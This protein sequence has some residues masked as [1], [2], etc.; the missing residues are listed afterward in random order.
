M[1]ASPEEK[2]ATIR[3]LKS[4]E[5]HV[6]GI[7]RMIEEDAYCMEVILQIRA[8]QAALEKV[9]KLSLKDHL[10]HCVVSAVRGD[11]PDQREKVL[12]EIMN[13]FESSR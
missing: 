12:A 3:R 9:A 10:D 8:V 5:G 11:D 6:R 2:A 4:I 7:S 13:V 1:H